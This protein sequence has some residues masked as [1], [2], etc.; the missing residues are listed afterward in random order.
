MS[1]DNSVKERLEFGKLKANVFFSVVVV[2]VVK[3]WLS[4]DISN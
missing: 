4:D 3:R 1:D 2:V